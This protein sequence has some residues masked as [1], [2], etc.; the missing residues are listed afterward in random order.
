[1]INHETIAHDQLYDGSMYAHATKK[2]GLATVC[3]HYIYIY[4]FHGA[5]SQK[6]PVL[7]AIAH[8]IGYV[9]VG[10]Y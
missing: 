3:N 6:S 8:P 5:T 2:A 10:F 4:D 7:Y 9:S 1:M